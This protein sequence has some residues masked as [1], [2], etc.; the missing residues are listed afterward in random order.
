LKP[1]EPPP[2]VVSISICDGEDYQ[3]KTTYRL[4]NV[5]GNDDSKKEVWTQEEIAEHHRYL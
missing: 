3:L 2:E 5:L 4:L 1:S